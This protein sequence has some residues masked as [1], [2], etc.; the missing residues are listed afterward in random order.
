MYIL[1]TNR[2]RYKSKNIKSRI[3]KTIRRGET[4]NIWKMRGRGEEK[5]KELDV[6]IR[7]KR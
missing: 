7:K 2:K 5:H 4:S 6:D 3:E 1:T